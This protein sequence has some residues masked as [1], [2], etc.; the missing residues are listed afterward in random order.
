[1]PERQREGAKAVG[2]YKGRP[3]R[4]DRAKIKELLTQMGPDG[5]R[6]ID[7]LQSWASTHDAR[8]MLAAR[9]ELIAGISTAMIIVA[10]AGGARLCDTWP[11]IVLP[12]CR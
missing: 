8:L 11:S 9:S 3:P 4:I 2:K 7:R 12:F 10:W 5:Y 6:E 1:M